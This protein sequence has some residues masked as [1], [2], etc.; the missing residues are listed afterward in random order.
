MSPSGVGVTNVT[1]ALFP[2]AMNGMDGMVAPEGKHAY[3]EQPAG[4]VG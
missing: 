1:V 4:R 3:E 2:G